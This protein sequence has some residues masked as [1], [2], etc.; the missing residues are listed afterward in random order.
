MTD[1]ITPANGHR[2]RAESAR[3][4]RHDQRNMSGYDA[5]TWEESMM[6]SDSGK[7]S[8]RP[9]RQPTR[10]PQ[11]PGAVSPAGWFQPTGG[12]AAP[13][14]RYGMEPARSDETAEPPGY[15]QAAY[16]QEGS[17]YTDP[18]PT[19][20][21]QLPSIWPWASRTE[22]S[23]V[24]V[25]GPTE[26]LRGRA[27]GPGLAAPKGAVPGLPGPERR[28]GWQLAQQVWQESGISWD[29]VAPAQAETHPVG[30]GPVLAGP[31]DSAG[32]LIQG[33]DEPAEAWNQ[34]AEDWNEPVEDWIA[35]VEDLDEP[36][37]YDWD[38]PAD[39]DADEGWN[40]SADDSWD[41]PVDGG[42]EAA[43]APG[44]AAPGAAAPYAVA[45]P[46]A[47]APHATRPEPAQFPHAA[48]FRPAPHAPVRP[49]AAWQEPA[50]QDEAWQDEAWQQP[51]P[52]GPVGPVGPIGPTG[53][54]RRSNTGWNDY[55]TGGFPGQAWPMD[56]TGAFPIQS[57]TDPRPP[58]FGGMPLGAPVAEMAPPM[59]AGA[60]RPL[61]ESDELFRAWQGS[62]RQ[63]AAPRRHWSAPWQGTTSLRRRGWQVATIGVPAAVIVTVGAGALMIL[64]GRANE[65]LAVRA[66]N[67]SLPAASQAAS[68]SADGGNAQGGTGVTGVTL[69]GYPG[70]H[71]AVAADSIWSAS[72]VS[73]AVGAADGHPAIW[74]RSGDSWTLVSAA[75]L[76]AIPGTGTLTAVAHGSAGWIAVGS[77]AEGSSG[78]VLVFA[79]TDGVTWHPVTTLAS[80]AGPDVQFYAAAAGPLG[81]AVVGRQMIG[82]RSFATLWW[83][84]DLRIWVKGDNGGLDGRL[85]ASTANAV[86]ASPAGFVAVGSHGAFASIWTSSDGTHWVLI[87]ASAP[88]GG[89]SA[90]LRQVVTSGNTIV[91]TGFATTRAGN[92]PL[93]VTSTDG[94][95]H[96]REITLP[97]PGGLGVVTALTT[98]D[99]KFIAAGQAGPT[100]AQRSVTWTSPD[101]LGWS[102]ATT[103]TRVGQ[104]T[105]LAVSDGTV[106]GTGST[107][108]GADPSI[109]TFPAP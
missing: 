27:G 21:H 18:Q 63:A 87:N 29:S 49:D 53:R 108:P 34:P 45:P 109:L 60:T 74:R 25:V 52:V 58:A 91:A 6:A 43:A 55:P 48:G 73:L 100:G 19:A 107:Q 23:Q 92:I 90:T 26:A 31:A 16:A 40:R 72:G 22:P 7:A 68:G 75:V 79:S 46:H 85:T 14:F 15:A 96:W 104:I 102:A 103:A 98:E 33:G 59:R 24:P 93:A 38:E 36:A 80:V 81:Y 82:G 84:A 99:N 106:T 64:T 65:M 10:Q 97:A 83:S 77:T 2:P 56:G 8:A 89:Q 47:A 44:A 101:G 3:N 61:G 17:W 66:N 13:P 35:P 37:D 95:A 50:R 94:G 57:P 11:Q 54:I 42:F 78:A 30:Y 51:G 105:A 86:A 28:S 12:E 71:G 76:G 32:E 1:A 20:V 4:A 69:A 5:R 9:T 70:Q 39:D 41:E 62:V 88:S 67:G